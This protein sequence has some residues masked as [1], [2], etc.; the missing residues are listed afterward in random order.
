MRWI[1]RLFGRPHP[2][3]RSSTDA[4]RD[5]DYH[6]ARQAYQEE[7]QAAEEKQ[8]ELLARMRRLGYDLDIVTGRDHRGTQ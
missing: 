3:E 5:P 8:I 4:S 6:A 1:M 7:K 2:P